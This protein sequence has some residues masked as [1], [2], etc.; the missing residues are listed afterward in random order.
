MSDLHSNWQAEEESPVPVTEK[1]HAEEP[2]HT[3][4]NVEISRRPAA[5]VGMLIVI[6]IGATFFGGLDQLRGQIAGG[7]NQAVVRITGAGFTPS[8]LQVEHGQTITFVNDTATPHIVESETLCSDTGY[9]LMTKSL[10]EGESDNF[11]ITPDMAQGSYRFSSAVDPLVTGEI[12]IVTNVPSNFAD[13]TSVFSEELLRQSASSSP[14]DSF[15]DF[16]FNPADFAPTNTQVPR[17]TA[18][19]IPTNPYTVD[20]TRVHP[21]DS[22]GNPIPEAFGDDPSTIRQ[23]AENTATATTTDTRNILSTRG[24]TSQPSTGAEI[25]FVLAGSIAGIWYASKGALAKTKV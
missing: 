24:P 20:S 6:G 13:I 10:F 3:P 16:G 18:S 5:I 7:G 9:C 12:V 25:W 4:Q 19:A 22:E 17:T 14:L 1:H 2:V 15:G 21:F 11:T 23:L 8:T